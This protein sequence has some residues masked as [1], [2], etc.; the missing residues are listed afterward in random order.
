MVYVWMD[1]ITKNRE[2]T[3]TYGKKTTVHVVG[4]KRQSMQCINKNRVRCLLLS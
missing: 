2:N 4:R 1:K 3:F